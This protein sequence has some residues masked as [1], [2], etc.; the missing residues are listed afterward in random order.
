MRQKAPKPTINL[1]GNGAQ[2]PA[3]REGEK[4]AIFEANLEKCMPA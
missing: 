4:N 3:A 2:P 1:I